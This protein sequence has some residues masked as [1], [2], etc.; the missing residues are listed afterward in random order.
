MLSVCVHSY[1]GTFFTEFSQTINYCN[2][3]IEQQST[4]VF[5]HS[6]PFVDLFL[7]VSIPIL[8]KHV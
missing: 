8:I 1:C 3:K 7:D 5:F 6:C 2:E 4:L